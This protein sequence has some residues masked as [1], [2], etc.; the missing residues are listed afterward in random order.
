MPGDPESE[1]QPGQER[2]CWL[3]YQNTTGNIRLDRQTAMIREVGPVRYTR[4]PG[5][6]STN[7]G[8]TVT[9]ATTAPLLSDLQAGRFSGSDRE[10]GL[11]ERSGDISP[12]GATDR[13]AASG[14][15]RRVLGDGI[16]VRT[17]P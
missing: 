2:V 10:P 3:Y 13:R 16:P 7:T 5:S 6:V 14:I 12:A 15:N 17:S 1:L 8:A 9:G 4:R 11:R